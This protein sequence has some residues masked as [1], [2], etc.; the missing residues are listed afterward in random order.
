MSVE[1]VSQVET[2][3][4]PESNETVMRIYGLNG[5]LI[6]EQIMAAE[7]S[8]GSVLPHFELGLA[9]MWYDR[10][11]GTLEWSITDRPT[12]YRILDEDIREWDREQ[13]AHHSVY[14]QE[15]PQATLWQHL[16]TIQSRN[17][18]MIKDLLWG[19]LKTTEEEPDIKAER[20]G[21]LDEFLDEFKPQTTQ[22]RSDEQK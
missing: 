5:E 9:N 21:A 7:L 13:D 12:Y 6:G 1:S 17:A 2:T 11:S 14:R 19:E 8:Q 15:Y 4:L 16:N 20:G 10:E 22:E 18:Q 3:Y